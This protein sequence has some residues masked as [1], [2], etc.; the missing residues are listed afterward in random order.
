MDRLAERH[1]IRV[2]RKDSRALVGWAKST[3][4]R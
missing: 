3:G 4:K 2:T 1:G